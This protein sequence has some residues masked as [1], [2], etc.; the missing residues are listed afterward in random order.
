MSKGNM[1]MDR[2]ATVYSCNIGRHGIY[3]LTVYKGMPIT[4]EWDYDFKES[5]LLK[6]KLESSQPEFE[7]AVKVCMSSLLKND[8]EKFMQLY[9]E[10]KVNPQSKFFYDIQSIAEDEYRNVSLRAIELEIILGIKES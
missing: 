4:V 3:H 1:K 10:L 2:D 6:K 9:N 8:I 7:S 5:E